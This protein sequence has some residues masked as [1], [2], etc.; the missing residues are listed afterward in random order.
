M[1]KAVSIVTCITIISIYTLLITIIYPYVCWF[2]HRPSDDDY[3]ILPPI[4]TIINK[5]STKS[6]SNK[7]QLNLMPMPSKIILL[8]KTKTIHIPSIIRIETKR[9]LSFSI[10][11]SFKDASFILYIDYEFDMKNN[12]YPYLGIDESYQL[13]ITSTNHAFLYAK[14]YVGIIRGLST[15]QQLQYHD[16]ISIPLLIFDKPQF[17]WRGLMLDV[18]R[19]F[20][21]ITII[22]QTINLM[23]LVKMNVLHLHLSDDQAFRLESK[24]FPRLHDSYEFYTQLDMKNLIEYARQ[25]A[26]RIVPEFDM[27]AHTTSWFIGYPYLATYKNISYQLEKTWGIKN[28]TMDVTRQSTYD[29]L[30]KFFSEMTHLFPDQYFHIGGDECEPYEWMQSEQIQKFLK[31]ERLYDHQGLQAYFTR[32]VEKLLNKYNRTMMGWDEISTSNLSHQSIIQSWRDKTSLIDAVH[33]GYHAILSHGFYLDHMSSAEYHYNNDIKIDI[34]LNK[35][36]QKRILGGE[37]C[38]WTEYINSNMVH[39]RTWPRTAA[40]A[41]RL[42]SSKYDKIECMYDRLV[43]MD[44]NFFHSN[45]EQYIK[46]LS[47][48]TKNVN[49]LKLLADLCEPLGLQGR[50]RTRNYTK[51]TLLNRFVDILKP[52]SEQIR[53]LIKTKNISLLYSTFISWK[54]NLLN[55]NSN[56]T[57]ILQLSENLVQLS[58]IGIRL[59]KLLNQ[60]QERQIVSSRWYYY[61]I[62]K[63]NILE[64]QIPEIRLAGV[65]VIRN[66]LEEFDPCSF[67]LINLSLILCFPIIVIFAQR[68]GFIRRR[69]LV[70]CLNLIYYYCGRC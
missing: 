41:E 57:N 21:P 1:L 13:N 6:C 52:E 43:I 12:S 20:I 66:L 50:D 7:N 49:S 14:T 17:I 18:A 24:Y 70:P 38:L 30:D 26:I 32:R 25:H 64:Y 56:D 61:Q 55:I 16:K 67:D 8:N 11:K 48:L 46:D 31:K 69:I 28:A 45:D 39:S 62:Y 15:F 22:K 51:Q 53:Q 27:P 35:T 2:K 5:K 63:L 10:L 3:S 34:I 36:E 40:I 23:Q 65:R 19:H 44:K 37:A 54:I 47:T 42:W 59:L 33:R 58:E 29:F 60:N 4:A 9:S 68:I